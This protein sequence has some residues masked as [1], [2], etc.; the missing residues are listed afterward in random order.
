KEGQILGCSIEDWSSTGVEGFVYV[1]DGMFH[2]KAILFQNEQ[3]VYKYDPKSEEQETITQE[4][5]GDLL[6]RKK[7]ALVTFHTAKNV[8]VLITSKYGQERLQESLELEKEYP[9]KTFYYLLADTFDFG[10]LEDFPFLEVYV[11][12]A[13]PRV[14]D[15]YNKLPRPLINIADITETEW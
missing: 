12:T 6:K 9:E 5:L 13:C 2:P 15:D 3:T 4:A 8:G 11:N 7:G 14:M 10:A 1:G